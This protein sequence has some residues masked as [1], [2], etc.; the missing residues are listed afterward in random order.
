VAYL[1]DTNVLLRSV[2][3]NHPMYYDAT[4]AISLLRNPTVYAQE[5]HP[6]YP[7]SGEGEQESYSLSASG[8]G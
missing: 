1:I 5:P 8:E 2:D 4:N 3:P 6:L 7:A